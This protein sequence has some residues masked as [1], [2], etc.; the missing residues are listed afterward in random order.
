MKTKLLFVLLALGI[1]NSAMASSPF[2]V[3]HSTTEASENSA[4]V[5]K[6]GKSKTLA[7]TLLQIRHC[8]S[9]SHKV[10]EN[11]QRQTETDSDS[12][13]ESPMP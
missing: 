11:S 1:T 2:V 5:S 8:N 6:P 4:V 3:E 12:L 9:D 13:S 10:D 7:E